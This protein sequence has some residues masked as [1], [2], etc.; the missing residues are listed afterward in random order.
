MFTHRTHGQARD[1]KRELGNRALVPYHIGDRHQFGTHRNRERHRTAQRHLGVGCRG[2]VHHLIRRN[3][4]AVCVRDAHREARAPERRRSVCFRLAGYIRNHTLRQIGQIRVRTADQHVPD[5]AEI[6]P[7]AREGGQS[8]HLRRRQPRAAAGLRNATGLDIPERILHHAAV[9]LA[10]QTTGIGTGPRYRTRRIAFRDGASHVAAHQA[11]SHR[12][13]RHRARGI[14]LGH[15]AAIVCAGQA[16]GIRVT[17]D[18]ARGTARRYGARLVVADQAADMALARNRAGRVTPGDGC[19]VHIAG[20]TAHI[21]TAGD[22]ASNKSQILHSAARAYCPKKTCIILVR[23]VYR[24]VGND[25]PLTVKA[26]REGANGIKPGS[27][28]PG[29]GRRGVDVLGQEV[30]AI[31]RIRRIVADQLQRI[32]AGNLNHR[33]GQRDVA[34]LGLRIASRG[35]RHGERHGIGARIRVHMGRMLRRAGL[36]VTEIPVPRGRGAARLIHELHAQRSETAYGRGAE[37][38]VERRRSLQM[39]HRDRPVRHAGIGAAPRHAVDV[40]VPGVVK[41]DGVVGVIVTDADHAVADHLDH[42]GPT[43]VNL[44]LVV[45][46]RE[47]GGIQRVDLLGVVLDHGITARFGK[48][49]HTMAQRRLGKAIR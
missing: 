18:R 30:V 36:P 6:P 25:I 43:G 7:C 19:L 39:D 23:T 27:A 21:E 12:C 14:A 2:L 16:A 44:G 10:D 17:R 45:F 29:R 40:V 24:K 46:E 42:D 35:A 32:D 26:A 37:L 22:R 47:P 8:L 38:R 3:G 9:V 5:R 1:S 20:E 33:G 4:I 48:Q 28:V 34:G 41:V 13:T 49:A 31:E 11:A 15:R